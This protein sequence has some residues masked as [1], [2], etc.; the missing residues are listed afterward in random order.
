MPSWVVDVLLTCSVPGLRCRSAD[1]TYVMTGSDEMNIRLWKANA[2][3]LLGTKAARQSSAANYKQ[4]I[5]EKF[6]HHPEIK[7]I[8]R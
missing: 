6:K 8:A 4:A 1:A 7:R 2:A 3:E 5:K